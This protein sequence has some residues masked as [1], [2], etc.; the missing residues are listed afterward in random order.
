MP[1]GIGYKKKTKKVAG[2]GTSLRKG[3]KR[4]QKTR[5]KKSAK[6]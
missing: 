1:K 3:I 5:S 2:H 6:A 4:I